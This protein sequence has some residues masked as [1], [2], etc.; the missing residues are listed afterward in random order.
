M[1]AGDL[2]VFEAVARLGG[3]SR[4]AA[5]LNTVQSNVTARI[6][7]LEE[8]V[9]A[10]LFERHSRGVALTPAGRRLMP[11]ALQVISL[12]KDARR[13]VTDNGEP[14][15]DLVVGSLE[16][17][18]SMHLAPLLTGFVE[19]WP[20]VDLSIRGGTTREGIEQV[21]ER[22]LEG[23]FVSGPV[24]HPDLVEETV[25][26]EELVVLTAPGIL[27]LDWSAGLAGLRIV[28]LRS[29]CSYRQRLEDILARR[30]VVGLRLLEFGTLEAIF[31][32]VAAGMGI[33]LLPRRMMERV[34]RDRRV[35]VHTLPPDEAM[36][37]TVFIRRRDSF[38][39]SAQAAFLGH[40]RDGL[41]R[42]QAA[43]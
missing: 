12:L 3:M 36:V 35:A 30:G 39:S 9:G 11:Y 18:L 15:G 20:A 43:E 16:T 31:G 38:V 29:G 1:D 24:N 37:D 6:R 32:C 2:R 27:R 10:G 13:A 14:A 34:W 28:V 33:T 41:A 5:E 26:R 4:A 7:L 42:V 21:L 25:F 17:T 23:A 19:R 22:R 40:V 8:Q